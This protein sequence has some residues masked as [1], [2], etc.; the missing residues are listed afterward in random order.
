MAEAKAVAAG[1]DPGTSTGR[2]GKRKATRVSRESRGLPPLTGAQKIAKQN[3]QGA[4]NAC[5]YIKQHIEDG[6]MPTGEV[7][8]ACSTLTGALASILVA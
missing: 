3:V 4:E 2:S 6:N 5:R 7:L 8:Q 1:S